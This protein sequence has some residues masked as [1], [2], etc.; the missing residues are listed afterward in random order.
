LRNSVLLIHK[1]PGI[2]SFGLVNSVKRLL[3]AKTGHAGTLDKS[4]EGLIVAAT[5]S[6]TKLLQYFLDS[7]KCYIGTMKLGVTT[8]TLD[9]DGE[10]TSSKGHGGITKDLLCEA[11]KSFA[12][13]IEQLPPEYS[14]L[15]ING[16]RASDRVRDGETVQMKPRAVEL[17]KIELLSFDEAL[18]SAEIFVHCTKGTY[19]RSLARDIGDKLGCGAYLTRLIRTASGNFNLDNAVTLDGFRHALETGETTRR[20][21]YA[22]NEAVSGLN[23]IIVGEEAKRKVR[24]GVKLG[25]ADIISRRDG[26]NAPYSV[27][28]EAKNLIAIADIDTTN[29]TVTYRNV[30]NKD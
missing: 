16:K 13:N 7:D 17:K 30:F 3:K 1:E 23:M 10:I 5:G 20:F 8:D 18:G 24:N 2:T 11:I 29:G 12:G 25:I 4:A 26:V 22:P 14:A 19:I 6:A 9:S 21:F 28:D 15:K 27:F